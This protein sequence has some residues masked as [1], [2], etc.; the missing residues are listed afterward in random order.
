ML[1]TGFIW[2]PGGREMLD[3]GELISFWFPDNVRRVLVQVVEYGGE[4]NLNL[5]NKWKVRLN[6]SAT[7]TKSVNKVALSELDRSVGKQLPFTPKHVASTRLSIVREKFS[8][9]VARKYTSSRF[10]EA[11]NESPPI[12]AYTLYDVQS[13][14]GWRWN[15]W[16]MSLHAAV[17]NLTNQDYESF[18]NRAMPGIN[19]TFTINLKYVL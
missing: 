6:H 17:L 7:F 19:Y 9:S 11:N 12:P 14:Y 3:N 15:K 16:D 4:V 1:I 10:P 8:I 13:S 2:I 18:I 5:T